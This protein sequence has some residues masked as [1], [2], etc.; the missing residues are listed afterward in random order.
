MSFDEIL[1]MFEILFDYQCQQAS[2]HFE[3][4]LKNP[5]HTET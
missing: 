4:V 2:I 5:I 3:T 1:I